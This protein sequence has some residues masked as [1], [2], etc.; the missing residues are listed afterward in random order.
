MFKITGNRGFHIMFPNGIILSTQFGYG[1][2]CDNYDK[3]ELMNPK[4][5]RWLKILD[6]CK[7]ND[8]R[9]VMLK[10]K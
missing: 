6:W 1:N 8:P 9:E 4:N 5:L 3:N 2:Y 7:N 10:R